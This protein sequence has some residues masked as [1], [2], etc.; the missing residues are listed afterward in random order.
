MNNL[1][2]IILS[3]LSWDFNMSNFTRDGI[4]KVAFSPYTALFG[5]YFFG[6]FFGVIGIAIFAETKSIAHI[7]TYLVLVGVFMGVVLPSLLGAVFGIITGILLAVIFY[8]VY[9]QKKR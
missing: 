8:R 2:T 5:S 4:I 9:A 7:F 3:T 6:L 1:L